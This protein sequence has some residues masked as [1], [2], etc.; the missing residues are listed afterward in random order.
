MRAV[1]ASDASEVPDQLRRAQLTELLKGVHPWDE[2]ERTHLAAT[3]E[4]VAA[5]GSALS[6]P[7]A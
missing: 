2:Q 1:T 3:M 4:W 6:D 5:W 7:E